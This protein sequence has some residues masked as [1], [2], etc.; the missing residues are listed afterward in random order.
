MKSAIIKA[1]RYEPDVNRSLEDFAN[2]YNI[3]VVPTRSRKPRDKALVE[4]QVKLIYNRIYARLRNRQFFSLD[5]LNE[6]IK[7]KIKTHNQTR[8]QQKPWCGEERFLAAEKHL[9]CPL[10]DTTFELKYYCE[11]KVANNNHILYWQ[12]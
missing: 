3:T 5:A 2:H 9:L 1:D 12:G 11:P 7:G 10:P 6:A 4:N 8:M